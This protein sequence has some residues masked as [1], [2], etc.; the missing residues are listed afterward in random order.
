M[1][2]T[3]ISPRIPVAVSALA[4]TTLL[5]TGCAGN[6][7]S[8]NTAV[9]EECEETY[10]IGF[11]HP[12]SEAAFISA[13]KRYIEVAA[14]ENGCI[15]PLFDSTQGN[16]LESQR[17]TVESWVTQ[18]IDAITVFPVD[19]A[20]LQPLMEQA[21]AQGTKWLTYSNPMEGSDGM[22]GFDNVEM[23]KLI[24][25]D[26]VE[27]IEENY[28][29]RD[30]SAAVTTL[31]VLP[32]LEGRWQEPI[33]AFESIGVPVVSAQDCPAHECGLA[34]AEDALQEHPDLRVFIGMTDDP[35]LGALRVFERAGI[36][37]DAAYL[38]GMDGSPEALTAVLEDGAYQ[39]TVALRVDILGE[40]IVTN[41][42]N[43]ITGSG[44][45]ESIAPI[46]LVTADDRET[47][48]ELLRLYDE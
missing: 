5:I 16:N 9:N 34:I 46:E 30:V 18:G 3:K 32:S 28:P 40:M 26:A 27:W 33:T 11:S 23:G 12:S 36:A 35:A 22:V 20:S 17:T 6:G 4:A 37:A 42:L 38:G 7:D 15:T 41:S 14:E 13:I 19:P 44:E 24:A 29:D 47:A 2:S 31:T 10:T 1:K 43:A 25:N 45:T 21:Q 48:E 8:A 39:S